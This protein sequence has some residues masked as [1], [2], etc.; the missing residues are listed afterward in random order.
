[1]HKDFVNIIYAAIP[2]DAYT[3]SRSKWTKR[4]FCYVSYVRNIWYK[5]ITQWAV[6]LQGVLLQGI[7]T[8]NFVESWHRNLKYNFMS[9]TKTPRPKKF[10]HGLVFDV[11]PSFRQ[12]VHASQ[13][14]TKFQG[15]TKGQADTYL[16]AD[17]K[18]IGVQI[19][20]V[21]SQLV[22]RSVSE[23]AQTK[24]SPLIYTSCKNTSCKHHISS[25]SYAVMSTQQQAGR[26]G[27]V[28]SCTCLFFSRTHSA[29][30]HMY[31]IARRLQY[32]VEWTVTVKPTKPPDH[33]A[34]RPRESSRRTA[35]PAQQQCGVTADKETKNHIFG[36]VKAAGTAV[37]A[38]ERAPRHA[39]SHLG[40]G[41]FWPDF[42][43]T[44]ML[45][46]QR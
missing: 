23:V 7:H 30:K 14:T 24:Q 8:N 18:D 13:S 25:L 5:F 35:C 33:D 3:A 4:E 22:S 46:S 15:I 17:L 45:N 27:K 38:P 31:I 40:L 12:A 9:R 44:Q 26:V 16:Q 11:E 42:N 32:N 2:F 34:S 21:T 1:M 39:L 6:A 10:L 19:L 37:L 20:A 28:N 36:P 41:E 29:C 43:P